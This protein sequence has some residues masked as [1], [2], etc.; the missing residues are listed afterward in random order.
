MINPNKIV[1]KIADF[2]TREYN[3]NN[4]EI[5]IFKNQDGSYELFNKYIIN[6]INNRYQVNKKVSYTSKNFSTLKNAVT[7]CIFD[8]RNKIRE[9]IRIE[10]LDKMIDSKNVAI[11]LHT[12]LINK[13]SSIENTLIYFAKLTDEEAKKKILLKELSG[14]ITESKLWQNERFNKRPK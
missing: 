7:W 14:F 13:S 1:K 6:K 4:A 10:Y 9:S 3:T 2:L 11:E 5:S 12:R 8:K